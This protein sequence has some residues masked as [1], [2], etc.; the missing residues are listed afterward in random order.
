[1]KLQLFGT[2]FQNDR[3]KETFHNKNILY[4]YKN[5]HIHK[6]MIFFLANLYINYFISRLKL[7]I[8]KSKISNNCRK[9]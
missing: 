5:I 1:M 6:L 9:F 7:K 4:Q 8:Y 3:E 2:I